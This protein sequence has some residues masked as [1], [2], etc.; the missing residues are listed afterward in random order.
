[1]VFKIW[2]EIIPLCNYYYNVFPSAEVANVKWIEAKRTLFANLLKRKYFDD[3][4]P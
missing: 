2:K 4:C 1:M 3:D